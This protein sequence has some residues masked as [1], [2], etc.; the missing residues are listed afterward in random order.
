M[1]P[2]DPA[3]IPTFMTAAAFWPTFVGLESRAP[4]IVEAKRAAFPDAV[5]L[6]HHFNSDGR[7]WG[8]PPHAEPIA[9]EE[10]L[11]D[12]DTERFELALFRVRAM[13]SRAWGLCGND[14]RPSMVELVGALRREFPEFDTRTYGRVAASAMRDM[15]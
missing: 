9:P 10:V 8:P 11:A 7:R 6:I 2:A 4:C 15:R 5:F 12:R 3:T 14:P 13:E 1:E